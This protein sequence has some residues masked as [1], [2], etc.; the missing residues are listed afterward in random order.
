[1]PRRRAATARAE[2]RSAAKRPDLA[3]DETRQ[4]FKR[5][6]NAANQVLR[7]EVKPVH[8]IFCHTIAIK[9]LSN[10]PAGANVSTSH[11]HFF[12]WRH[13]PK[14]HQHLKNTST[15]SRNSREPIPTCP[16][17]A[18]HLPTK[19]QYLDLL[20]HSIAMR[21]LLMKQMQSWQSQ[22][23]G[24]VQIQPLFVP[25]SIIFIAWVTTDY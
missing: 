22:E 7:I 3:E 16:N 23:A 13:S 4:S 2:K 10:N 15:D 17:K 25:D 5:Q 1:M 14:K 11:G 9:R 18:A 6:K 8:P 21:C 20:W 19:I 24:A 12:S